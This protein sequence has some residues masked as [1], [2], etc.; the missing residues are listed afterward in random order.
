MVPNSSTVVFPGPMK[1]HSK[2]FSEDEEAGSCGQH[3]SV[4]GG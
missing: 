1:A 4:R 2:A 3:A